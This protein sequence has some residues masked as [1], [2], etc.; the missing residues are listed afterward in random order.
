MNI[1]S[2]HRLFCCVCAREIYYRLV[3]KCPS[4]P[5]HGKTSI[6]RTHLF[7]EPAVKVVRLSGGLTFPGTFVTT[8]LN[9]IGV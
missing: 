7:S 9:W 5:L 8:V 4:L 6:Y 2:K 3:R 1:V